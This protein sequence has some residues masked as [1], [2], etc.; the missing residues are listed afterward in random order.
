MQNLNPQVQFYFIKAQKWQE[1]LYYLRWLVLDCGL[2]EEMKWGVPGYTFQ[3]RNIVLIQVFKEYGALLF[4][5]GALLADSHQI[6][7]R[8]TEKVQA[9]RQIRFTDLT[10]L[11]EWEP[12][13]RSYIAEAIA[14][15]KSGLKVIFKKPSEEI[16]PEE[17]QKVLT[18]NPALKT[19]FTALT[20]GRQR[21]YLLY[22]AAPKQPKTRESRIQKYLPQILQGKGL[23][24]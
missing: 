22:F 1:S 19:A 5:K 4:I 16:V 21:A 12:V 3:N 2:T 17:W 10:Q 13:I 15:E 23:S 24:D 18:Q 7:I 14:I 9:A 20:P 6:L 11:M 8:Q